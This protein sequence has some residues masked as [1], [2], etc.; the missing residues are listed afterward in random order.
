MSLLFL[1]L[2][3]ILTVFAVLSLFYPLIGGETDLS[4]FYTSGGDR[5]TDLQLRQRTLLESLHDLR[6]EHEGGKMESGEFERLCA[7]L[8]SEL[9]TLTGELESAVEKSRER[10]GRE[11]RLGVLC[12][13]C[14]NL[15]HRR[16]DASP[17]MC[18]QC[19]YR[20]EG[21]AE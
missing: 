20:F 5:R 2:F 21:D 13:V 9:R 4:V 11:N 18:L 16:E 15:N 1:I 10:A 3:S 6:I 17:S 8:L 14:G 12:P 19:A 7:P